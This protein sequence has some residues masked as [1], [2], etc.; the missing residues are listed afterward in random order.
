MDEVEREAF[1][2]QPH[3]AVL[4]TLGPDGRV[5]AVPV[6]YLYEEGV[7]RVLTGRGSAKHRNVQRTGRATICVD[8]RDGS[9][10]YVTAEGAVTVADTVSKAERLVLRTRYQGL[11]EARRI[12]DQGGHEGLVRLTLTPERWI[13]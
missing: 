13:G 12:V 7:F 3:T 4:S 2:S 9:L 10:R 6:W 11:A 8:L 5:H 1:L